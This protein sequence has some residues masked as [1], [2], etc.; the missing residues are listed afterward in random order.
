METVYTIITLGI[1]G[2][3]GY[4]L[5]KKKQITSSQSE[6]KAKDNVLEMKQREL[7]ISQEEFEAKAKKTEEEQKNKTPQEIE[8]YW[9]KKK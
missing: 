9:N 5:F 6:Y 3:I 2:L 8:D 4:V 7:V 1:F